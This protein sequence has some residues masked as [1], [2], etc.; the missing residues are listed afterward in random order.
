MFYLRRRV[1]S[2]LDWPL[3][4]SIMGDS[5]D[6]LP[7]YITS[8]IMLYKPC[9]NIFI[10][11]TGLNIWE[12]AY[13]WPQSVKNQVSYIQTFCEDEA[14]ISD[15]NGYCYSIFRFAWYC[16]AHLPVVT[17]NWINDV[18]VPFNTLGTWL[19]HAY[20]KSV[21]RYFV[22]SNQYWIINLVPHHEA[23]V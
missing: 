7:C 8:W 11:Q 5:V 9:L 14:A 19:H 4:G 21:Y 13:K 6:H 1:S 3:G 16:Q 17:L 20:Y 15:Q 18:G 12:V 10:N 23:N 2:E 22:L